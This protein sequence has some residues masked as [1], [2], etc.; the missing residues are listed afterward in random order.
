MQDAFEIYIRMKT[1]RETYKVYPG[2]IEDDAR[3]NGD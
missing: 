1:K 3:L 2:W